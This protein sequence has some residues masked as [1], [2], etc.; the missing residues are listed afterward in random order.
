MAR[1]LHVRI[2]DEGI[3]CQ[4]PMLISRRARTVLC[5]EVLLRRLRKS[6]EL[7]G[8]DRWVSMEDWVLGYQGTK[9][10][11]FAPIKSTAA[12]EKRPFVYG[13]K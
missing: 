8:M 7:Y 11:V 5:G 13:A 1:I 6:F 10:H 2:T 3:L 9:I 12:F 4:P